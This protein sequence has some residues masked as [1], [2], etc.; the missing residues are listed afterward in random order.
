MEVTDAVKTIEE[1]KQNRIKLATSEIDNILTK[2][3]LK[4]IAVVQVN[5]TSDGTLKVIPIVQLV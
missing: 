4:L 3:A 2:H 1:D 5:V